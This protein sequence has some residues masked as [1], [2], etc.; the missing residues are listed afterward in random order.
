MIGFDLITN[1]LLMTLYIRQKL[2]KQDRQEKVWSVE[3]LETQV[4][5]SLVLF[6]H[7]LLHQHVLKCVPG[8]KI[9]VTI[10]THFIV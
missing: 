4:F 9:S 5:L 8:D 3:S 1:V 6:H 2:S 10:E 7:P